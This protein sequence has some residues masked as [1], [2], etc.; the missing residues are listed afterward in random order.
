MAH[1]AIREIQVE[2]NL[3]FITLTRGH[4]ATI[5]AEDLHI[6]QGFHWS[7]RVSRNTVYGQRA[8]WQTG[9]GRLI[10][11]HREIMRAPANMQVDHISGD[12]LDN[13]KANLRLATN[14]QNACNQGIRT[15]NS[16]GLKGVGWRSDIG[17]WRACIMVDGKQISLGCFDT[18]VQASLAYERASRQYHGDFG[19]IR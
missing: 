13:R 14:A 12:G 18:P 19:R 11:L 7:A 2:G 15:T 4:V 5:D 3:A 9:K 17:K 1:A 8:C 16:S 6:V 10:R